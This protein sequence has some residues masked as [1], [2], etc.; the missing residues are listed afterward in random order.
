MLVH[1]LLVSLPVSLAQA[2]LNAELRLAGESGNETLTSVL[3]IARKVLVNEHGACT[4][5]HSWYGKERQHARAV[6]CLT[7][8][9]RLHSDGVHLVCDAE[10][11]AEV[12]SA[13]DAAAGGDE[14]DA[15]DDDRMVPAEGAECPGCGVHCKQLI[16]GF[17]SAG[18]YY[19]VED[20]YAHCKA[21][22][23]PIPDLDEP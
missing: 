21:C 7:H 3:A 13:A 10:H 18:D 5:K 6:R 9:L 2:I 16:Q 15:D 22:D 17:L 23:E 12:E 14:D 19:L 4:E 8:S 1:F 11:A 20:T